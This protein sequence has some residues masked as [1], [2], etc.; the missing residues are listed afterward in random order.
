MS[1]EA[2]GKVLVVDD[3]RVNRSLLMRAVQEQGYEVAEAENG[4]AALARLA[5]DGGRDIDAVLLDLEMP[6]LD[7]YET[8][9]RMKADPRLRHLPVIIISAVDDLTSVV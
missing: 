9:R 3:S 4:Q 5:G 8:L 6:E 7:G 1:D 2:S